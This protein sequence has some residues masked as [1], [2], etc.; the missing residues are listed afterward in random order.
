MPQITTSDDVPIYFEEHGAGDPLVLVMGLGAD[1]PVWQA[2]RE[3]YE[4]H[5][6]CIVID[7]RGVGKSGKPQGPYTTERMA[8]DALEVLDS[9]GIE[10]T[11][12]AGIS[13][14]GA[15]V[16]QMVLQR[17][18]AIRSAVIIASWAR[19]NRYGTRV[20][21]SLKRQKAHLKP[22]DFMEAI[23]IL[24]FA[25]PHFER[26]WDD[27]Q[28]GLADATANP[29]PQPLAAFEAQSDACITHDTHARL[30]QITCPTLVVVGEQDI[31][32]P[33]PFSEEIHAGIKGS[34][35]WRV[36]ATGHAVHWEAL[37]EFN[38]K[39]RDFML[40]VS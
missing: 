3:E 36:P 15:I 19:L 27:L 33:P 2:H 35:L 10:Q 24:I 26:A 8:L 40:E 39:T 6:R 13:M 18:A 31:F 23:Q 30:A 20:F 12:A 1:G 14:G 11:H 9:L 16:Q 37:D 5:F 7:N 4:K 28:Q 38:A 21:E 25:A 29:N 17:P 32:T 34:E 22:A